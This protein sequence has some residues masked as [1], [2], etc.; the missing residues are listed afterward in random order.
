MSHQAT[1]QANL[2][3]RSLKGEKLANHPSAAAPNFRRVFGRSPTIATV[4]PKL[5]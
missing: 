5:K 3:V 1:K 4:F 2:A